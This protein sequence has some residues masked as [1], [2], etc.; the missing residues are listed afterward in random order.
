MNGTNGKV[1]EALRL[2]VELKDYKNKYGKD[3]R[4]T[5][6]QPLV[7]IVAREALSEYDAINSLQ[8]TIPDGEFRPCL[9]HF[10]PCSKC[11]HSK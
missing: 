8:C 3:E 9:K 4:Y 1:V 10:R 5:V 6:E 7:W 11:E 2:L